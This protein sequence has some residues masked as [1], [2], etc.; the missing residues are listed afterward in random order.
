[1]YKCSDLLHITYDCSMGGKIE[2]ISRACFNCCDSLNLIDVGDRIIIS[3]EEDEGYSFDRIVF[4]SESNDTKLK[5][6]FQLYHKRIEFYMPTESIKIKLIFI[7]NKLKEKGELKK[8]EN[9]VITEFE[10]P[11]TL[12]KE[13]SEL[14]VKQSIRERLL[15]QLIDEPVKFEKYE[16]ILIP[17]VSKIEAIKAKITS[18]YVPS[19]Y[20]SEEYSWNY[21]GWE[22]SQNY[23]QIFKN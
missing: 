16:K 8:M 5:W 19:E 12:A 20:A 13:L 15:L 21:N 22:I 17:I 2:K 3:F 11:E 9:N 18:E 23:C 6:P 10:I 4:I 7:N 14:L 1:M